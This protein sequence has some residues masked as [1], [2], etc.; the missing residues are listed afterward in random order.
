MRAPNQ[1]PAGV[2]QER[3]N[4]AVHKAVAMMNK[5][6]GVSMKAPPFDGVESKYL[7]GLAF[8]LTLRNAIYTS[9]RTHNL[10]DFHHS[11]SWWNRQ[12]AYDEILAMS[13]EYLKEIL[14]PHYGEKGIT[15]QDFNHQCDLKHFAPSLSKC[16]QAHVITS[17]NDFL[18][19]ATDLAWLQRTFG[20]R[21]LTLLERGG[22][23]GGVL[24][25]RGVYDLIDLKLRDLKT[26]E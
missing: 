9:Q 14:L 11:M 20:G 16:P 10:G 21:R 5:P 4:N 3:V 22:H 26:A 8:R 6:E 24:S 2:R 7:I 23:V 19:S 13:F 1:W 25:N 17:R 12:A 18:L 15:L